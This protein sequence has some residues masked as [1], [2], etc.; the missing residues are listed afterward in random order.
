MGE[1][2][3]FYVRISTSISHF[4]LMHAIEWDKHLCREDA[5]TSHKHRGLA[6]VRYKPD[7][8]T[9]FVRDRLCTCRCLTEMHNLQ[10]LKHTPCLQRKQHIGRRCIRWYNLQQQKHLEGTRYWIS[11]MVKQDFISLPILCDKK[12]L[13]TSQSFQCSRWEVRENFLFSL[14]RKS[15]RK[16][17]VTVLFNFIKLFH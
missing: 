8:D 14:L 12:C 13:W 6:K 17:Q 9:L 4:L 16:L 1:Q 10:K 3:R 2:E 11:L 15:L 7:R 5:V